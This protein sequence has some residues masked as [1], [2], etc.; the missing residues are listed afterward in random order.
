MADAVLERGDE[1]AARK[2]LKKVLSFPETLGAVKPYLPDEVY[3]SRPKRVS[4]FCR[5]EGIR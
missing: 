4:D 1:T 2:Y 3:D 5:K